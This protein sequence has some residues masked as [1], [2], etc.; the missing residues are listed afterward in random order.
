MSGIAGILYYNDAPVKAVQLDRML[1]AMKACGA[2]SRQIYL[3]R[4]VGIGQNIL[5]IDPSA[6]QETMPL[7]HPN[8][9]WVLVFDG[10]IDNRADLVSKLNIKQT[11]SDLIGDGQLILAAYEKWRQA[12]SR[13]LIGD[14]SLAIWD[15]KKR[16]LFCLRDHFGVKPFYYYAS[17][18]YYLFA[19]NPEGILAARK[20]QPIYDDGRIADFLLGLEGFDTTSTFYQNLYRLSPA[21]AMCV[22]AGETKQTRYWELSPINNIECKTEENFLEVFQERFTE[23]VRCRLSN[24]ANTAISLSGGLDFI[25]DFWD[26]PAE[27]D[28]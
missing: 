9:R 28:V 14:Y 25:G 6:A 11:A 15:R 7:V 5:C 17:E 20:F 3:D 21:H 10:R 12:C 13:Y 16:Q 27:H 1:D 4:E 26:R 8:Q 22:K 18:Y 23:A 19:S 24:P 2:H